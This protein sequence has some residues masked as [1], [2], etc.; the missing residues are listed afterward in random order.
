VSGGGFLGHLDAVSRQPPVKQPSMAEV[1]KFISKGEFAGS[2]ALVVGGSRGLGELTAKL[3][4]YGGADVV[5]TYVVGKDDAQAVVEEIWQ[6]GGKCRAVTYDVRLPAG[7][8]L[9]ILEDF[10]PTHV[11]Y[12]ATP[13]ISRPGVGVFDFQRFADFNSYYVGGF[14]DLVSHYL[15]RGSGE[16]RVFYPSTVFVTDRPLQMTEYAMSKAAGELLCA[17]MQKFYSNLRIFARRLPRLP[18]DQ[19]GSVMA[20]EVSDASQTLIKILRDMQ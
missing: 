3:L 2:N 11:Y 17:D 4:A 8:Q 20:L 1:A 16:V 18:S 13:A 10:V 5:I 7:E 15:A 14:F 9:G 12:F 6:T 19:T